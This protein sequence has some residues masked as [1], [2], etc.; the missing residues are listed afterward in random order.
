M[1]LFDTIIIDPAIELPEFEGDREAIEWQ[2]KS[3]GHPF[4]RTF[5]LSTEGRLLRKGQSYRDLR[6]DELDTKAKERGYE[7]WAA[8][9]AAETIG[10]FPGW[11]RT[12]EEEWWVDHHQHGTF[13]FHGSTADRWYSYEARF[14]KGQLDRI[15]LLS[16][17]RLTQS[18]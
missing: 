15:C 4:M 12:I 7:S 13:E 1:G 16:K 5:K 8:L 14:T 9:E 3:I 6:Q 10:P 18:A 17:E 11:E 2:T